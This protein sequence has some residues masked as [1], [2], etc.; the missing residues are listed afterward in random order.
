MKTTTTAPCPGCDQPTTG[1]ICHH[2]AATI[3]RHL[4][5]LPALARELHTQLARQ[6]RG[7]DKASTARSA[8]KPLPFDPHAADL[9]DRIHHLLTHWTHTTTHA[10]PAAQLTHLTNLN[11]HTHPHAPQV[12]ADLERWTTDARRCIDTPPERRYLGPCATIVLDQNNN[13][14][15]CTG[16]VYQLGNKLPTCSTCRATHATD[17]RLEWIAHLAADQLVTAYTAAAALSAWGAH[18]KPDLIRQWATRGRLQPKGHDRTGHP[19]YRFDDCRTLALDS[20][21]RRTQKGQP[22]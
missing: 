11:W 1:T 5:A 18:I 4:A 13:P 20:I 17:A 9:L 14:Q 21:K 12:L 10:T 8:I 16:D 7:P 15:E 2:C 19:V 6:S 22:A 3:H